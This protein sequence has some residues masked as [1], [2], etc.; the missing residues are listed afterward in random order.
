MSITRAARTREPARK[1]P[2]RPRDESKDEAIIRAA[3]RLFM[4]RGFSGVSMDAIAEAAGVAKATLYARFSDKEA[5]LSA[6]I[7]TKCGEAM[8]QETLSWRPTRDLRTALIDIARKF[9]ALITDHE[10]LGMLRLIMQE[11]E[12]NPKLPVVFFES[13]IYPTVVKLARFFEAEAARRPL[14]IADPE[15]AAWRFFGMVKGQEHMR[16]MLGLPPRPKAE[17][18]RH[19]AACADFFIAAHAPCTDKEA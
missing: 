7:M 3:Q 1:G 12:R 5:L 2:G 14:D 4:E 11:G 13:A 19:I 9:L 18:E 17:V 6:A 10:A 16:A 8:D 15:A